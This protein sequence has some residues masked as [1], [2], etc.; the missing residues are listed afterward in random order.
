MPTKLIHHLITS[1]LPFLLI[2]LLGSFYLKGQEEPEGYR[3]N[4]Q[5]IGETIEQI[6]GEPEWIEWID[7]DSSIYKYDNQQRLVKIENLSFKDSIWTVS[8]NVLFEYTSDG[9]E[10]VKTIQNVGVEEYRKNSERIAHILNEKNQIVE[11]TRSFWI[12]LQWRRQEKETYRYDDSGNITNKDSY[13]FEGNEWQLVREEAF[14]FDILGDTI[15]TITRYFN[16]DGT[17]DDE[18]GYGIERDTIDNQIIIDSWRLDFGE[19]R[20]LKRRIHYLNNDSLIDSLHILIHRDNNMDLHIKEEY[21][22]NLAGQLTQETFFYFRNNAWKSNFRIIYEYDNQGNLIF[23][24]GFYWSDNENDWIE[25]PRHRGEWTYVEDSLLIKAVNYGVSDIMY[26]PGIYTY[27]RFITYFNTALPTLIDT[28]PE[29]PDFQIFPNPIHHLLT[30]KG[31]DNL[32][33]PL[34]MSI[35]NLSGQILKQQSIITTT[36]TTTINLAGL[37]PGSYFIHFQD[38]LGVVK[39]EKIVKQ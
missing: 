35:I 31:I 3:N 27:F 38:K 2:M 29:E 26:A 4:Q 7:R 1:R 18:L 14:I 25:N 32:T 5:I 10:Y 24:N 6:M 23:R 9:K 22:Y 39:V 30:I 17:L 13:I 12:N 36:P 15:S 20:Y 11:R 21:D 8:H 37:S 19:F 28:M 34:Q 16:L 33:F